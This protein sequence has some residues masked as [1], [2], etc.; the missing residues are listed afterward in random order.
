MAKVC[1]D[2]QVIVNAQGR[3]CLGN[4]KG[5]AQSEVTDLVGFQ[6]SDIVAVKNNFA[7]RGGVS[8]GNDI[9]HRRFAGPIG[10]GDTENLTLC[11]GQ[12]HVHQGSQ[13]AK[14]LG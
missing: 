8:A 13:A 6:T 4:L 10:P 2:L 11:D 12:V 7:G 3:K 9:E 5:P 14:I 1:A